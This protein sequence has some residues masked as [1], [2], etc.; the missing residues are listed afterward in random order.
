MARRPCTTESTARYQCQAAP[1]EC[2]ARRTWLVQT[3]L[4]ATKAIVCSNMVPGRSI[5]PRERGKTSKESNS[6]GA[7]AN[8]SALN[9]T[10]TAGEAFRYSRA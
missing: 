1:G 3:L 9:D 7:N 4:K 6:C 5:L 10:S 2:T 8:R